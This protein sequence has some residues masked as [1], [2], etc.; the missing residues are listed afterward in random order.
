MLDRWTE[1]LDTLVRH[2]MRTALTA[3]SVAWGIFVLVVLIGVG[4][5]LSKGVAW[6][7]RDD[8]VNSIWLRRGQ[9]SIPWRGHRV[10]RQVNFDNSDYDALRALDGVQE[11]TGRYYLWGEGT[12]SYKDRNGAYGVRAV[13]PD[14]QFL[15]NTI[16]QTG[17]YINDLDVQASRKTTVIGEEVA[18]FLFRGADP[19]GKWIDINRI[20]YR[21]VGT[22]VDE[23]G[24]GEVRMVY[25]P[26]STAQVAYG[27]GDTVHQLMFTVDPNTSAEEAEALGERARGLLARAH[28]FSPDDKRA[29]RIR[30]NLENWAQVKSILDALNLFTLVVGL[31]TM[32]AGV[33]GVSNILLVSV[34]ER[35]VEFGL[36]KALGA[37]PFSIVA[38]VLQEAILLTS[39]AGWVGLVGGLTAIESLARFAPE[40]DYI[41]DPTVHMGAALGAVFLLVLSGAI[42][43]FFPAWRAASVQPVEALRG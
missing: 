32:M 1:I 19:I 7:F 26:I 16:V 36:R 12:V 18:Q 14:H 21:V 31:G 39:V 42:A 38:L 43:G 37:T 11:L 13:H 5:G 27:G 15:E 24:A 9:T 34:A 28:H 35:S 6:Q 22:F 3:L 4:D 40:I 30:N 2:R 17:R 20:Q 41:R 10:G 33:V 8:A 23:G 29:V 25:I